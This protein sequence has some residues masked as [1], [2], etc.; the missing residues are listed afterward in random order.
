MINLY[1]KDKVDKHCFE[2]GTKLKIL[3]EIL[4]PLLNG[5]SRWYYETKF[6]FEFFFLELIVH[7]ELQ[8]HDMVGAE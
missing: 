2:D 8:Y 1:L 5:S 7:F 4:Q 3:S 6:G